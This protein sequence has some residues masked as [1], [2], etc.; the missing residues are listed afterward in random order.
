ME[1]F[2]R[3]FMA[4]LVKINLLFRDWTFSTFYFWCGSVKSTHWYDSNDVSDI[5]FHWTSSR[6]FWFFISKWIIKKSFVCRRGWSNQLLVRIMIK[7]GSKEVGAWSFIM[8][9]LPVELEPL[10]WIQLVSR[11]NDFENHK[12]AWK[13][14]YIISLFT[15]RESIHFNI[16]FDKIFQLNDMVSQILN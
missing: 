15:K 14:F 7:Y 9:Q 16:L 10:G 3:E 1:K 2:I 6:L 11:I 12:K 8:I 5:S 13:H 4:I